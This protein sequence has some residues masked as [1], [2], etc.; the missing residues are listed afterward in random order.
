MWGEAGGNRCGMSAHGVSGAL[1]AR[2]SGGFGT[3]WGVCRDGWEGIWVSCRFMRLCHSGWCLILVSICRWGRDLLEFGSCSA[4]DLLEQALEQTWGGPLERCLSSSVG[5]EGKGDGAR[6][7]HNGG[8]HPQWWRYVL[9]LW[10]WLGLWMVVV[11]VLKWRWVCIGV[12]AG[13]IALPMKVVEV[14]SWEWE[15][16]EASECC[17]SGSGGCGWS[18]VGAEVAWTAEQNESGVWGWCCRDWCGGWGRGCT[19]GEFGSCPCR[20]VTCLGGAAVFGGGLRAV[21]SSCYPFSQ[22]LHLLAT[23]EQPVFI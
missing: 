13:L 12:D 19:V 6:G 11:T 3:V 22:P 18:G 4:I 10:L 20:G 23:Y 2:G 21:K 14:D 5:L 8:G 1:G 17:W 15:C 9:G 7:C 16:V